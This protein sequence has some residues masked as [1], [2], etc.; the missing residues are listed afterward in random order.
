MKR[1]KQGAVHQVR[2]S[3]YGQAPPSPLPEDS[4]SE[5]LASMKTQLQMALTN[6]EQLTESPQT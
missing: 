6:T 2:V 1:V 4:G 3:H 5:E